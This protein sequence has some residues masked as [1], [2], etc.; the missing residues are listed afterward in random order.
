MEASPEVILKTHNRNLLTQ[1]LPQEINFKSHFHSLKLFEL[2][3]VQQG[4]ESPVVSYKSS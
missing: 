2:L 4:T 1:N 3:L